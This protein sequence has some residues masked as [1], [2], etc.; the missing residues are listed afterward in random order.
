MIDPGKVQGNKLVDLF[1]QLVASKTIISMYVVGTGYERLTCVTAVKQ[2]GQGNSLVVD[3]P[4]GF[5][6]AAAKDEDLNIRFNFNGPDHLEYL[7]ST[8]GG[9]INGANVEIPFP[10]YVERLQRRRN[11]RIN[12]PPGTRL[13]FKTKAVSGIIGVINISLGGVYGALLKHSSKDAHGSVLSTDQRVF[14]MGIRFPAD[15]DIEEQTV[16]IRKSIVRRVEHD[17][18][19]GIYKYAFEFVEIQREQQNL[20]TQLIYQI[21]RL[22]LQRR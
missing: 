21:Q 11:F 13:I 4:E 1:S 19:R 12:T 18:D 16:E 17:K 20:L 14:K 15:D 9:R 6:E 7:F 5:R 3:L 2:E 8:K 10:A 22:Q